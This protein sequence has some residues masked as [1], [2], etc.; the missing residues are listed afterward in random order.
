MVAVKYLRPLLYTVRLRGPLAGDP[1]AGALHG[2]MVGLL[3]YLCAIWFPVVLPH[4]S[5]PAAGDAGAGFDLFNY[6]A[7][8]ALL[9][10]GFLRPASWW[11][12]GATWLHVTALI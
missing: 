11:F 5:Q 8:L 6:A 1:R 7:T 4:S 10:L 12:V 9:R 3:L 2:L